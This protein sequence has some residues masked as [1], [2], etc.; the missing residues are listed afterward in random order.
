MRCESICA[1]SGYPLKSIILPRF[2]F[3]LRLL[4]WVIAMVHFH[5]QKMSASTS[6]R[7]PCFR[8]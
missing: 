7:F 2:I 3:S 4:I 8:K 1:I 6:W 5:R